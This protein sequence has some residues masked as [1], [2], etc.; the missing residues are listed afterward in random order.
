MSHAIRTIPV[1]QLFLDAE[2]PRHDPID[3]EAE[4]IAHLVKTEN[5]RKLAADIV[6]QG[7]LSP[8]DRIGVVADAKLPKNFIALEGNR[9]VCA[10][11]LLADPE[12]ASSEPVRKQFRALK[13]QLASPIKELEVVVFPSRS[14]AKHWLRLRHEGALDGVG[15]K[16]WQA[17]QIARFNKMEGTGDNP[18]VLALELLEYAHHRKLITTAEKKATSVTTLTRF[19]S[20]PVVRHTLAITSNR[21]LRTDADQGEF[22][23]GVKKFLEDARTDGGDVNSRT[24]K[25]EREAYAKRIAREG[26]SPA[27]RATADV[28][29]HPESGNMDAYSAAVP[30]AKRDNRSP[31]KRRTVVPAEFQCHIRAAVHKR[32]Y[33]ELKKL[34]AENFSFSAAYLLRAFVEL[35]THAYC[36]KHQ[37]PAQRGQLDKAIKAAAN[38]L[39]QVY[40]VKASELKGLRVMADERDSSYSPE[41]LGNSVHGSLTP[42]RVELVRAWDNIAPALRHMLDHI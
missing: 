31:D 29:L 5:I 14:D 22:D 11:K 18:N 2:N 36:K 25:S 40:K 30:P 33:D 21:Q 1:R 42:T 24:N 17:Q 15:I 6:K 4:I 16:P 32:V 12:K 20:S 9:R 28:R 26:F 37:L 35:T 23:H 27:T 10:L 3:N 7:G 38:H 39:A 19:L 13:S 41:T 34:D 8:F